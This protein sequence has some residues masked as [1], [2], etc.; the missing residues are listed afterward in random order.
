MNSSLSSPASDLS[1]SEQEAWRWVMQHHKGSKVLL[2]QDEAF[3]DWLAANPQHPHLYAKAETVWYM[4]AIPAHSLAQKDVALL[5]LIKKTHRVANQG[6][7]FR[8]ASFALASAASILL[9]LWVGLS[10]NPENWLDDWQANYLTEN[11]LYEVSLSDGSHLTLDADTALVAYVDAQQRRLKLLRG[12]VWL[13]VKSNPNLPFIVETHQGEVRVLGT[14]FEVRQEGEQIRVTLA[15][16]K[17]SVQG[18][19]EHQAAIT[20]HPGQQ[21]LLKH[22][23][24][25]LPYNVDVEAV[26]SWQMGW[27]SFYQVPLKEVIKRLS[28]YYPGRILLLNQSLAERQV[29]GTFPSQNPQAALEALQAVLGFQKQEFLGHLMVLH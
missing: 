8:Y 6:R 19:A 14:D 24:A 4:T 22:R 10:G 16:G 12:A 11:K 29:S 26:K 17:V 9:M 13:R 18:F 15:Q 23:M 20:L 21:T 5:G 28:P 27:L 3:L 1:C 2:D 7:R 25:S